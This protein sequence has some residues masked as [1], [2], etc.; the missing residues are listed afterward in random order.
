MLLTHTSEDEFAAFFAGE[1]EHIGDLIEA[2]AIWEGFAIRPARYIATMHPQTPRQFGSRKA[3][4]LHVSMQEE[5]K[6]DRW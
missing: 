2:A 6:L 1:H 4:P 5:R 3:T